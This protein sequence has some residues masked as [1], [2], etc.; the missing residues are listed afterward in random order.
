MALYH[1]YT[2]VCHHLSEVEKV[3]R[4][5]TIENKHMHAKHFFLVKT[6]L[7]I[8]RDESCDGRL[9]PTV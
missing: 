7:I 3:S 5:D 4:I 1:I 8:L 6:D 9:F 2:A